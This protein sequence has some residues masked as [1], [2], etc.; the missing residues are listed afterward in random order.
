LFGVKDLEGDFL[1][2]ILGVYFIVKPWFE[3]RQVFGK[4]VVK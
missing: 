1:L 4:A 3:Q 2:L